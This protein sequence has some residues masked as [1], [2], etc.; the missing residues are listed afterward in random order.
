MKKQRIAFRL[1]IY[2]IVVELIFVAMIVVIG[3]NFTKKIIINHLVDSAKVESADAANLVEESMEQARSSAAY[4]AGGIHEYSSPKS[5]LQ[6]LKLVLKLQRGLSAIHIRTFSQ[7]TGDSLESASS[8][9]IRRVGEQVLARHEQSFDEDEKFLLWYL[10]ILQS[11]KEAWS[12]PYFSRKD[13]KLYT[14]FVKPFVIENEGGSEEAIIC[15]VVPLDPLLTKLDDVEFSMEGFPILLTERGKVVYHPMRKFI[16]QPISSLS[17]SFSEQSYNRLSKHVNSEESG[18]IHVVTNFLGGKKS[19]AVFWPIQ[20]NKWQMFAVI[21]EMEFIR[22]LNGIILVIIVIAL[23]AMGAMVIVTIHIARMVTSPISQLADDARQ[24]MEDDG[25]ELPELKSEIDVL[26]GGFEHMKSRVEKYHSKYLQG[27]KDREEMDRELQ[28]AR[29]IE[30][31]MVPNKFPLYPDRVEFDCFGRLAPAKMVGGDLFDI[32]LIDNKTLCVLVA[33]S[34]GKGV[35]AAMFGVMTRT[36]LRNLTTSGRRPGRIIEMLNDELSGNNESDMFVTLFLGMIDL[37]NG[38]LTYTNAGHPHPF[39]M[40]ADNSVVS[41]GQSH[42]IPVG[43]LRRQ[44]FGENTIYLNEGDTFVGYSDGVTEAYDEMSRMFGPERLE[45]LLQ[46]HI[47]DS[48]ETIV[49][50]IF[51]NVAAFRNRLEQQDDTTAVA[52]RFCKMMIK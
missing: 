46:K 18:F 43:V 16:G 20:T 11:G 21:P 23:L 13:K 1:S 32:F 4:I 51:T 5:R 12:E 39:I 6:F 24:F 3:Y 14:F 10:Q 19:V 28:L 25:G 33:D 37:S 7:L 30:M 22:D 26:T 15:C 50:A 40:R 29:D 34:L 9:S 38:E 8:L 48:P 27:R 45:T 41:L 31:S 35:P 17:R 2:L 44:T 52:V 49:N 36:L 42:G 47:S